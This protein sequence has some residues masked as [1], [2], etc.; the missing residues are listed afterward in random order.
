MI[1]RFN[2]PRPKMGQILEIDYDKNIEWSLS[3]EYSKKLHF[4]NL[5]GDKEDKIIIELKQYFQFNCKDVMIM[6]HCTKIK[7]C[8]P[9]TRNLIIQFCLDCYFRNDDDFLKMKLAFGDSF[10]GRTDD[11]E[12]SN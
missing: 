8:I 5:S 7:N 11:F 3:K 4:S 1:V 2:L 6:H 9:N 10:N 12:S